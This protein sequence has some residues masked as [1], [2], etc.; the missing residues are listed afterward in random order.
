MTST[1]A[2]KMLTKM[3]N[4]AIKDKT[5]DVYDVADFARAVGLATTAIDQMDKLEEYVRR[6]KGE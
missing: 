5:V 6:Y 1:E 3:Y 2:K 4:L